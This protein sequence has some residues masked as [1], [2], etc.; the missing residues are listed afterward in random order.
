MEDAKINYMYS[1]VVDI[2]SC[3]HQL[4]HYSAYVRGVKLISV[5]KCRL[6]PVEQVANDRQRIRRP[7]AAHCRVS[8]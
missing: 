4:Y 5:S 3:R 8:E 2:K 6:Q 1:S 7:T